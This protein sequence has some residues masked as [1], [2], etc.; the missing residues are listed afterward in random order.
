MATVDPPPVSTGP[1]APAATVPVTWVTAASRRESLALIAAAAAFV[2]AGAVALIVFWGHTVPIAG[3]DSAGTF[4]SFFAAGVAAVSFASAYLLD[5]FTGRAPARGRLPRR[6]FDLVALALAHAIIFLIIWAVVSTLIQRAFLGADMYDLVAALLAA[7]AAA[8]TAYASFLSGSG[9]T[10]MR[11]ATLIAV[12]LVAGVFTSMLT[13]T[14]PRWWTMN[15]SALG[16]NDSLSST[17]FNVTLILSGFV[18]TTLANFATGDLQERV[19]SAPDATRTGLLTGGLAVMGVALAGVGAV[20]VNVNQL[21]HNIASSTLLIVFGLLAISIR[22][23]VPGLP[24]AFIVAG[25]VFVV[26]CVVAVVLWVPFGYYNL[27][28]VEIVG[29]EVF[30]AWLVLLIRNIAATRPQFPATA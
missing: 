25:Y 7:V 20:P 27:T 12:L 2:V 11:L 5:R 28:A 1:T 22:W 29:A 3:P 17:A 10:T 19:K 18:V 26:I 4:T 23:L 6:I 15:F 8:L 24:T 13:A 30:L 16:M 14:D 21:V 9:M